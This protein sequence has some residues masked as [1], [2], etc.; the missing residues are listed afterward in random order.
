LWWRSGAWP[1]LTILILAFAVRAPN[2]RDNPPGFY[3]DEASVGFN[4]FMLLTTGHDEH[5][6]SWPLLFRAFGEYKLPVFIYSAIPAVAALGLREE[7][8]RLT[9]VFYGVLTVASTFLVARL[10]LGPAE[11]LFASFVVAI[12]PWHVIT[13]ALVLSSSHFPSF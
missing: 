11:A 5:G 1:L 13:A 8:V 2:L 4:A 9:S 12:V 10:L 6:Q 7:S 3:A